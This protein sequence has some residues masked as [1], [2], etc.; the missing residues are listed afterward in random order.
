[1]KKI[2]ILTTVLFFYCNF[3][4]AASITDELTQLNN[5]YKEG[6]I[7]EEEFSKA[8]SI[9]LKTNSSNDQ[10]KT[11]KVNKKEKSK[12]LKKKKNL[13]R[14]SLLQKKQKLMKI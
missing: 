4:F 14:K 3:L 9:L 1:M 10:S 6:A 7:T 5:L 8:K 11:K 12:K 2:F 13:K